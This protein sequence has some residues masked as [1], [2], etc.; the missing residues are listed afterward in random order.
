[1]VLVNE[2]TFGS[3]AFYQCNSGYTLNGTSKRRCMQ[4]GTWDSS[5]PECVIKGT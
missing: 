5:N 2:T 3:D 4:N 1:M